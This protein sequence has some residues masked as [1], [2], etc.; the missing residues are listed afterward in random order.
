MQISPSHDTTTRRWLSGDNELD[1]FLFC[2]SL[3]ILPPPPPWRQLSWRRGSHMEMIRV[4]DW[5]RLRSLSVICS[6]EKKKGR[7]PNKT[8]F[9]V[10]CNHIFTSQTWYGKY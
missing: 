1:F 6:K 9:S 5:E 3:K 7:E 2:S 4:D 8:L 10:T